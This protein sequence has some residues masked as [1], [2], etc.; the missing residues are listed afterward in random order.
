LIVEE[1]NDIRTA[2]LRLD[3]LPAEAQPTLL[4]DFRR[5]VDVRLEIYRE[6]SDRRRSKKLWLIQWP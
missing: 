5:Y 4:E 1:V 2:W 3:V 6:V